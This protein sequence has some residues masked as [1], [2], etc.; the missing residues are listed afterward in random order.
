MV[1]ALLLSVVSSRQ[2]APQSILRGTFTQPKQQA[3]P[4]PVL[5]TTPANKAAPG[6]NAPAQ[7]KQAPQTPP[8]TT[9]KK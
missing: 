4:A 9:N 1:I 5:P 2:S 8:P 3:A 7:Q 6:G